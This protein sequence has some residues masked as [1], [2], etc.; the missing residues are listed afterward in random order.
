MEKGVE[1][2][3]I[4]FVGIFDFVCNSILFVCFDQKNGC[5]TKEEDCHRKW[6]YRR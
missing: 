6:G 5:K 3:N 2:G 4:K 1:M